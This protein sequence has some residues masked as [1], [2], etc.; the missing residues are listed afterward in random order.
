[1]FRLLR[2]YQPKPPALAVLYWA[3]VTVATLAIL[4]VLFFYLDRFLPGGGMF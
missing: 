1:M 2:R 3:V 4:F